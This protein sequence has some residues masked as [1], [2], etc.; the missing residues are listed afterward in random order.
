MAGD[1]V[2]KINDFVGALKKHSELV[3]PHHD[4]H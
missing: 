2:P 1:E 4:F 3:C